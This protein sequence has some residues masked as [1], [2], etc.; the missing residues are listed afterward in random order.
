MADN[1]VSYALAHR[2][3]QTI[4]PGVLT[5][6]AFDKFYPIAFYEKGELDGIEV[7]MMREYAA[8]IGL[9]VKFIRVKKWDG[10]WDLPRLKEADISIGGI[11]DSYRREDKDTEWSM[12]YYY[13]NRSAITL[14][15]HKGFIRTVAAVEGSTGYLDAKFRSGEVMGTLKRGLGKNRDLTRLRKKS[16]D[17]IMYGDQ[18][19]RSVIKSQKKKDL[20]MN[21]WSIVPTLVPRDGETFSFPTRLGSGIAVSLTAF[22][23]EAAENGDL[24]KLCKKF[25]MQYPIYPTDKTFIKEQYTGSKPVKVFKEVLTQFLLAPEFEKARKKLPQVFK[26]AKKNYNFSNKFHTHE[27]ELLA[28]ERHDVV[29][30]QLILGELTPVMYRTSELMTQK[31]MPDKEAVLGNNKTRKDNFFCYNCDDYEGEPNGD[32]SWFDYIKY[33]AA[34]E[35]DA[36]LVHY[37]DD[38]AHINCKKFMENVRTNGNTFKALVNE[39]LHVGKQLL[40]QV[41]EAETGVKN[42]KKILKIEYTKN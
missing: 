36:P 34:K 18:V 33:V 17:G 31:H 19:S 16:I 21:T 27:R 9:E 5:V 1:M 24:K 30:T 11:A 22:L 23:V 4:K 35:A 41:L 7:R 29:D 39:Y 2:D 25:S 15:T 3:I 26:S 13:V 12:P 8:K 32:N 6:A 37:Y 20:K 10:I 40:V 28:L 38:I 42:V 14:K